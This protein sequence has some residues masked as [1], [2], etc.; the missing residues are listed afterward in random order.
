MS[1]AGH[2]PRAF[3]QSSAPPERA[4]VAAGDLEGQRVGV[5][6][7][8]V[9]HLQRLEDGL[10]GELANAFSADPLDHQRQHEVAGIAVRKPGAGSE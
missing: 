3:I 9:V 4:L 2:L 10:F 1:V 6:D 8:G 5:D 7:L